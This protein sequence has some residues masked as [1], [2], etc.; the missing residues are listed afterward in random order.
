MMTERNE[1]DR[2]VLLDVQG[3]FGGRDLWLAA[4]GSAWARTVGPPEAAKPRLPEGRLK[5]TVPPEDMDKL[6]RLLAEHDLAEMAIPDRPGVPDEA[7]PI[8]C[9]QRGDEL[10][11]V[12]KWAR[13]RHAAF[14]AIYGL[15]KRLVRR[16][17]EPGG[18]KKAKWK[19]EAPPGFPDRQTIRQ[20]DS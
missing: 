2:V 1:F 3:L 18:A 14:D 13:D 8:V 12:A 9:V 16:A 5:F 19:G 4:D 15:L 7:R 20:L 10:C 6:T 17:A 11:A